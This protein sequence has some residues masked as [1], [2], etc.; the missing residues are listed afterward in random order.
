MAQDTPKDNAGF[1]LPAPVT[2]PASAPPATDAP[3]ASAATTT[4]TTEPAPAFDAA[5][6]T[7]TSS[8]DTLVGG[9]VLLLLFI[10]FFF[11]KNA[12]ANG[13]VAKRVPPNKANASGW[14][15]FIFLASLATGVVLAAVNAHKF[16]APLFMGP[17]VLVGLVALL[18]T[19]TSSRR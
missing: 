18:L 16:L 9:V 5:G 17:L 8:R 3:A 4:A 13:L 6:T 12:Y 15:L 1:T 10:A 2:A 14:W 7:D 19:F 11:A